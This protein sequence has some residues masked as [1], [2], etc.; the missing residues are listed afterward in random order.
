VETLTDRLVAILREGDATF[1]VMHHEP[2]RTSEEAARVRGTP[3]EQGAKALVY[4][5][6]GVMVLLVLP[7]NRRIDS[8]AFKRAFGITDLRLIS[9]DELHEA[10]GL[11]VGAVPPFGTLM[12]FPTYVDERLLAEPR[13]SFNAG[14]RTTS[15][16]LSTPDY[17]RLLEPISARFASED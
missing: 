7:G 1:T 3:P 10:T 16:I 5:A 9:P 8:R 2:V 6:D 11:E 13:I 17:Q 14:S 4:R 15:I 12:G